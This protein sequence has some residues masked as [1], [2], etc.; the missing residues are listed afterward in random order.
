MFFTAKKLILFD[1]LPRG[2]TFNQRDFI[3]SIFPDLKT[4][5]VN[6]RRQKTASTFW[7]E[8]DSMC[9]NGSKAPSKINKNHISRM[10]HSPY[11][12]DISPC[13][14]WLFGILKQ[15]LRDREFSSS[16][17]I[18]NAIAQVR[19]DLTLRTT[20]TC[21][22]TGSGVL[23]RSLRM[24]ESTVSNNTRFASSC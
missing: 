23:P 10:P 6:F 13:D 15:I 3:N 16:D 21:S 4:A 17:E 11:S 12:P 1:V 24:M 20:R 19:N 14:F 8:L 9:H 22:G 18:E 7:A 5:N 2:S